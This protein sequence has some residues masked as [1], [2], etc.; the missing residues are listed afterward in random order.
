MDKIFENSDLSINSWL[1]SWR[2]RRGEYH[3]GVFE[4]TKRSVLHQLLTFSLSLF[5][6]VKWLIL[7]FNSEDSDLAHYLGEWAHYLEPKLI[8][9]TIVI[10]EPINSLALIF[11][12]GLTS[13][14]KLLYWLDYMHFDVEKRCFDKLSIYTKLFFSAWLSVFILML[15]C[16]IYLVYIV[17]Q[18]VNANF[19]F[20]LYFNS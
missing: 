11:Y 17:S 5:Q 8:V 12:F 6:L 13:N 10:L 19:Y 2:L 9:N 7:I 14:P 16:I 15:I 18:K 20:I 4:I 1:I 3:D